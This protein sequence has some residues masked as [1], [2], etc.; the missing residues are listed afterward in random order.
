MNTL[1]SLPSIKSG[2]FNY[3][4]YTEIVIKAKNNKII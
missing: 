4:N 3:W 2:V 1:S